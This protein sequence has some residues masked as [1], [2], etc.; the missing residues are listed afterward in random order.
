MSSTTLPVC[1]KTG[2]TS[3]SLTVHLCLHT[4]PGN[5]ECAQLNDFNPRQGYTR[6]PIARQAFAAVPLRSFDLLW[7]DRQY[8]G[9]MEIAVREDANR[10]ITMQFIS[11]STEQIYVRPKST[12][13][14]E[15]L[16]SASFRTVF[17]PPM[18]GLGI[19]EPLFQSPKIDQL[20]ALGRSGEVLR[21][22]LAA[23]NNDERA[24]SSIQAS[25]N[26]LFGY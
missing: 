11:D 19:D 16:R 14:P 1:P 15:A 17:V 24:W 5:R 3:P 26:K 2:S 21:N 23:A 4:A 10:P 13:P 6:A 12:T 25:I 18:S 20:L 7:K 9:S 22:L 8:R